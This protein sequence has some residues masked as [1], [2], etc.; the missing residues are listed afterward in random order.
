MEKFFFIFSIVYLV[1]SGLQWAANIFAASEANWRGQI[2]VSPFRL[3]FDIAMISYFIY[4][5]I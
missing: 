3:I 1:L 2:V 4:Y 5:L